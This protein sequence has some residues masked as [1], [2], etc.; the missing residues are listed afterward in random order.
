MN[1]QFILNGEDIQVKAEAGDRLSDILARLAVTTSVHPGCRLGSCGRCMVI[2]DGEATN[3]CLVPAFAVRNSEIITYEGLVQT[4]E[5]VLIQ[6]AIEQHK[7]DLCN[8]CKPA[9]CLLISSLLE[10]SSRPPNTVIE[11]ILSSVSCR[12]TAP[13]ALFATAQTAVYLKEG[14]ISPDAR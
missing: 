8:F 1:I 13:Q 9:V 14:R 4:P 11:E 5:F 2:L 3:S 7:L 10:H 12:C 6:Q